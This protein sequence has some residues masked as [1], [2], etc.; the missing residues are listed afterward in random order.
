MDDSE[1]RAGPS[2]ARCARASGRWCP[3]AAACQWPPRASMGRCS[4]RSEQVRVRQIL[5][6]LVARENRNSRDATKLI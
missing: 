4:D 2:W 3:E 1:S 5:L 6:P